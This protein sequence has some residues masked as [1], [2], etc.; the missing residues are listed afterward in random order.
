MKKN[1]IIAMLLSIPA[2][3]CAQDT[4]W[5]HNADR[6][7]ES[8]IIDMTQF[9]SVEFRKGAMY[10]YYKPELGKKL[11]HVTRTYASK[12]DYYTFRNPGRILYKPSALKNNNFNS[13]SSEWCFQRSKESEHFI[14]FW[15]PKL[16]DNPKNASGNSLDV[17]LLLSRAEHLFD[18]Y[19][20][21]LGFVIRGNSKSTD[22]YK[23]EIFVADSTGW[24][25]TGS[26]YDTMIGALWCTPV[27]LNSSGGHTLAHE[28][29]HSFQ[30]LV[31]CDLGTSH[32]W[33]YGFG[34][35]G[36]G[37]CMW[38]E[39]CAQWQGFKVYPEQQFTN[40]RFSEYL[41]HCN[42]NLMHE[43]WR[44]ANFFIQDYWCMLYGK[45]FIGTQWR[46]ETY[47]EDPIEAYKR[48]TGIDQSAFNDEIFN[49]AQRTCTWDIDGIRE[50]GKSFIDSHIAYVNQS[51]DD[52]YLWQVDSA[53]CVENYGYNHIRVNTTNAGDT[54]RAYFKG[55]AGEKG[56]RKYNVS[57][58]GWRYGF[59]AYLTDGTRVYGKPYRDNEGV[60]EFCVPEGTEKMWFVVT[61]APTTHWRHAW[62]GSSSNDEQWP[63]QVKFEG[64]NKYGYFEE[65]PEDYQ[66]KDTTV[67]VDVDLAY[68]GSSYSSVVVQYD[69]E[70]ASKALGLSTKQLQQVQCTSSANPGFIAING[71]NSTITAT[72]TTTTSSSTVL[73]H[74][75]NASGNVCGYGNSAYIFAEFRPATF[76]CY[77][78]QYPGHLRKGKTYTIKQGIRYKPTGSTQYYTVTFVVR[79]KVV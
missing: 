70:A 7:V 40:Y 21:S 45:K 48:T 59:V 38:W 12:Y 51:A 33:R 2:I 24:N 57:K 50:R 44:Y 46:E 74:W 63:Y 34:D 58:A 55:I 8:D 64:T 31:S 25:A 6:F 53:H 4:L 68:D 26:G 49:F 62:D 52:P 9:D 42:K 66:R 29:G 1:L 14:V 5:L 65:Y 13:S 16:G 30:Y 27:A 60:A 36:S 69:M 10:F 39:S 28:I 72:T 75:F 79:V 3:V 71:T 54:V 35:N 22:K 73:G 37:G 20:D 67:Y 18:Y 56:Y 76:K 61:G 19:A 47:P 17:D 78:G 32:G 41:S 77:V 23:I 15:G 11:N 43:D